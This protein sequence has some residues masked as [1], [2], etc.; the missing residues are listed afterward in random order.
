MYELAGKENMQI[1]AEH[2]FQ[3]EKPQAQTPWVKLCWGHL[4]SINVTFSTPSPTILAIH[5]SVPYGFYLGYIH[6]GH[7]H[8]EWSP[9]AGIKG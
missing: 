8:E 9:D 6:H 4:M 3:T 1:F 2:N 5:S 7:Q